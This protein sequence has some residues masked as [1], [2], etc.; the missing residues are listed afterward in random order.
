MVNSTV[1]MLI[2]YHEIRDNLISGPVKGHVV[3]CSQQCYID[4]GP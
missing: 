4:H 2:Y 1:L 3:I